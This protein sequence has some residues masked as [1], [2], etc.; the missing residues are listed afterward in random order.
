MFNNLNVLA[1]MPHHRSS[2]KSKHGGAIYS[3]PD[4]LM[5]RLTLLTGSRRA[6]NASLALRN[7][8]REIIDHLLKTGIITKTQHDKYVQ[9]NLI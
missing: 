3:N 8:V 9:Q 1:N 2:G 6:D 7:E 5:K 4:D